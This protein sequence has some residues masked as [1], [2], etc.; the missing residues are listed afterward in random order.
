M[1]SAWKPK[2]YKEFN[3]EWARYWNDPQLSI[4]DKLDEDHRV[5]NFFS[6]LSKINCYTYFKSFT[7][8]NDKLMKFLLDES[9]NKLDRTNYFNEFFSSD[10]VRSSIKI[11]DKSNKIAYLTGLKFDKFYKD[12]S[13]CIREIMNFLMK[14][15]RFNYLKDPYEESYCIVE[16]FNEVIF[17]NRHSDFLEFTSNEP[18]NDWFLEIAGDFTWIF[19]DKYKHVIYTILI[20]ITD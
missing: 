18:W 9:L 20:T 4:H 15:D 3:D 8:S 11:L 10:I 1:S 13:Y 17:E 12:R 5:N 14:N 19:I 2:S 7:Y 6:L 16:D